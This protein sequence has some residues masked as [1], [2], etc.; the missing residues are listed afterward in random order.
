MDPKSRKR[1]DRPSPYPSSHASAD[2]ISTK[3]SHQIPNQVTEIPTRLKNPQSNYGNPDRVKKSPTQLKN[4]R[5]SLHILC[6][7]RSSHY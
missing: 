6:I 7:D 4:L 3:S 1:L 5:S 2:R